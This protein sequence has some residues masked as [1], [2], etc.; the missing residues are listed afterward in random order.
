M[1]M[2]PHDRGIDHRVLVVRIVSQS[3]EKTLP[4]TASRVV[5]KDDNP[6]IVQNIRTDME[7][8]DIV[9]SA[10]LSQVDLRLHGLDQ[11]IADYNRI[12]A[13]ADQ[14]ANSA[15]VRATR[16]FNSGLCCLRFVIA[17]LLSSKTNR[18]RT[19][20]LRHCPISGE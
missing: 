11:L 3:L 6:G 9:K 2:G 19:R 17:D 8:G 12:L 4:T 7:N 5:F 16:A 18:H 20:S 10:N 15:E 14:I 13:E 1:L